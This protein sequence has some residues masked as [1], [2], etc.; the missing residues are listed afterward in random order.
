MKILFIT[1][2][3]ETLHSIG[4]CLFVFIVLPNLDNA[5]Q[6][7]FIVLGLSLV[8]SC[9]KIIF[10]THEESK[11]VIKIVLDILSAV[12]QLIVL[13]GWPVL[14]VFKKSQ[15]KT[16]IWSIPLSLFLVSLRWWEN[17]ADRFHSTHPFKRILI[18]MNTSRTKL[19]L[20]ASLWKVLITLLFM[21]V[22][23]MLQH[24]KMGHETDASLVQ[25]YTSVF[26]LDYKLVYF[27]C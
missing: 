21:P 15:D 16:L 14:I 9:L 4:L 2:C 22:C 8:P 20:I 12:V 23:M 18:K 5:V 10:R 11:K 17:Y 13:V 1:L 24:G 26:D 3:F 19:Q 25:R 27:Y 7:S 6:M